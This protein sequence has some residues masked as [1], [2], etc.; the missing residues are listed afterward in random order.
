MVIWE[1]SETSSAHV[2]FTHIYIDFW[3]ESQFEEGDEIEV[4]IV[5]W[6]SIAG[7]VSDQS[8]L[9]L[10]VLLWMMS[11]THLSC[12]LI[13]NASKLKVCMHIH[14]CEF[15]YLCTEFCILLGFN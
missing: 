14:V 10:Q 12:D 1:T 3:F 11:I 15:Q 8:L 9:D 2:K 5:C 4:S 7:G 13:K 6:K